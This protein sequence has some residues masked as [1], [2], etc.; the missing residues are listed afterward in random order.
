M[1]IAHNDL[2]AKL[3]FGLPDRLAKAL[4]VAN[5]SSIEM[6]DYLGV[7]RTTISNYTSGRT[8]VKKQTLRL[9]A[10]RTGIPLV[11]IETGEFGDDDPGDGGISGETDKK[12]TVW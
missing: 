4:D 11:W 2:S 3:S 7:S 12:I 1:S 5:V 6:A 8:P 9:W 10:M